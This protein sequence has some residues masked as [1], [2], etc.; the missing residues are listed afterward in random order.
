MTRLRNFDGVTST[1]APNTGGVGLYQKFA[2]FNQYFRNTEYR[3][4]SKYRTDMK[5]IPTKLPIRTPNTDTDPALI[6]TTLP[7]SV[8]SRGF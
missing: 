7:L 2:I 1:G 6:Y 4:I 3:G 8:Y 5:K